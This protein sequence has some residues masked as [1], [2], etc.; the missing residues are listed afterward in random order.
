MKKQEYLDNATSKIYNKSVKNEVK[1][2]LGSHIDERKSFLLSIN[3]DD[4]TAEEKSVDAMGDAELVVE[5]FGELH[6]DFYNPIWDIIYT[7]LLG[8]LLFGWYYLIKKYIVGD[9][10]VVSVIFSALFLPI[11]LV[12]LYIAVTAKRRKDAPIIFSIVQIGLYGY[13]SY[14]LLDWLNQQFSGSFSKMW[15]YVVDTELFSQSTHTPKKQVYI[16]VGIICA[17]L[18]LGVLNT[19][20]FQ[21]KKR[22]CATKK[23]DNKIRH[24]TVSFYRYFAFVFLAIAIFFGA[25]CYIDYNNLY[26][27]YLSIYNTAIEISETCDTVEK[28]NEYVDNSKLCFN[29]EKN[30]DGVIT[31]YS[32]NGDYSCITISIDQSNPEEELAQYKNDM[33]ELLEGDV[34]NYYKDYITQD[35][36]D[37]MY[38]TYHQRLLSDK[39]KYSVNVSVDTKM[40]AKGYDS[41]TLGRLLLSQDSNEKL[42]AFVPFDNKRG[43]DY[44]LYKSIIPIK[45]S[46]EIDNH[47]ILNKKYRFSYMVVEGNF[48]YQEDRY[49]YRV[50]DSLNEFY[51]YYDNVVKIVKNNP[52]ISEKK[53][54]KLTQAVAEYPQTSKEDYSQNVDMLGSYF[55]SVK[56]DMKDLYDYQVKYYI[57]EPWSNGE[58]FYLIIG[59]PIKKVIFYCPDG[60]ITTGVIDQTLLYS[61]Y[62]Y[63][64]LKKVAVRGYYFDRCGNCFTQAE[65]VPYYTSDGSKLFLYKHRVDSGDTSIG[66]IITYYITDRGK[67]Y[68]E[69]DRCFIDEKGY[70]YYDKSGSIKM[71][72]NG[73]YKSSSGKSYTKAV[74]TS[75]DKDGTIIVQSDEYDSGL[76]I[77]DYLGDI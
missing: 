36:L 5:D 68:Y 45:M 63:E 17:F 6:N 26:N 67:K 71:D 64:P 70:L 31:G 35:M 41:I 18:M 43:E 62:D 56:D 7:V 42:F 13:Y 3:Y 47:K 73:E 59:S 75:W 34:G 51:S 37:S 72:D 14:I 4:Q 10:G 12:M 46:F 52:S 39:L 38:E 30:S 16:W 53:L 20:I 77:F 66:N 23:I 19:V 44:E 21:I 61:N 24:F 40:F 49:A 32:L 57:N 15:S 50:G 27:Q 2:E 65:R 58:W 76:P 8:G 28:L 9:P 29:E 69:I 55:D 54:A 22:L 25:K 11:A 33:H 74:E 60:I 48:S 1:Q